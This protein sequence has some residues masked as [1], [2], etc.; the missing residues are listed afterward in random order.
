[1]PMLVYEL[2][3][4]AVRALVSYVGAVE[5]WWFESHS[6]LWLDGCSLSTQQQT[7]TWWKCRGDQGSKELPTLLLLPMAQDKSGAD[8]A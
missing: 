2:G 3:S 5:G 6:R 7:F 8:P 1:M 4:I